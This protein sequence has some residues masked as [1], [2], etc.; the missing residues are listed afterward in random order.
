[1][2]TSRST[3]A[4]GVAAGLPAPVDRS[5]VGEVFRERKRELRQKFKDLPS[6]YRGYEVLMD[7]FEDPAV[8]IPK[9][10]H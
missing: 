4:G 9:G 2:E 7:T 1:M 8:A 5:S 10:Q 3:H 6:R